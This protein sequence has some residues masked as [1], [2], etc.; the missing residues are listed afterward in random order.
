MLSLREVA[1]LCGIFRRIDIVRIVGLWQSIKSL[2]SLE[3]FADSAESF[4]NFIFY[5]IFKNGLLRLFA[6]PRN[7]GREKSSLRENP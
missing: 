7:D 3:S 1:F 4:K 6:K 2:K 5:F